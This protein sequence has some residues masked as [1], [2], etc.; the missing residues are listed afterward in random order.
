MSA[1]RLEIIRNIATAQSDAHTFEALSVGPGRWKTSTI[2]M[3]RFYSSHGAMHEAG[4]R[5]ATDMA[6]GPGNGA[7]TAQPA[8]QPPRKWGRPYFFVDIAQVVGFLTVVFTLLP[9]PGK[10]ETVE[11]VAE[12]CLIR[13]WNRCT[14]LGE[15]E[16]RQ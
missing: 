6:G 12:M 4:I 2:A 15:L 5:S 16:M 9:Q 7:K 3:G 8:I 1:L 11:I 13:E 14:E 10:P